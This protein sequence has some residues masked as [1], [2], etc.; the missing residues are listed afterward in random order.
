[1]ETLGG[2]R[3]GILGLGG[4]MGAAWDERD[5]V[6][7]WKVMGPGAPFVTKCPGHNLTIR[8]LWVSVT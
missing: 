2:L 6:L 7:K 8:R 5:I 4:G 1:M 3:L